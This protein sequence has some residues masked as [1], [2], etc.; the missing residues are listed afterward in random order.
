MATIHV[1]IVS[2]EGEIFSGE[3]AMVFAPAAMGD[4]GIA[5]RHAPL[6][7]TLRPGEVRVLAQGGGHLLATPAGQ[8]DEH[9]LGPVGQQ[10]SGGLL[11]EPGRA[12]GDEGDGAV[13][14]LHGGPFGCLSVGRV[15]AGTSGQRN[16]ESTWREITSRW[17]WLVPS[18]IWVTLAS[19]MKRST[20]KSV[21]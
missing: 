1:D 14:D 18:K 7:T 19:R 21:V 5:P 9:D 11:A 12:S 8:V 3:A 13:G 10:P 16:S 20:G 6:L 2:A 17:I 15:G 4:I